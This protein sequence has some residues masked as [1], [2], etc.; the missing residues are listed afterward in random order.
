MR[1]LS[2]AGTGILLDVPVRKE[3]VLSCRK[4]R[5]AGI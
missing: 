3:E 5:K 1:S 2:V 4:A